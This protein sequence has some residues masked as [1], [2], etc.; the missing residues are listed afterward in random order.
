RSAG[1]TRPATSRPMIALA[2]TVRHGK[3]LSLWNTKPRSPP[4]PRTARPSSV[5][6]PELAGSRPATMR[7]NVVLPQPDGPTSAMNSP[8]STA[9]LMSCNARNSPKVLPRWETWSLRAIR[10]NPW[11]LVLGPRHEPIFQPAETRGERDP[12]DRGHDHAGKQL[13]HVE[14]VG[15]L[16]DQAPE[17]RARAEQLRHHHPDQ[18]ASDP[19]LEPGKDERH[20]GRQ[21]HLEE[22][23]PRGRAERAQHLDQP[24][25]GGAQPGLGVDGHRK[26]HQEDDHQHLRPDADPEPE[27][28]QR[29]ERD[30]RRGV[31]SRDPRL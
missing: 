25:A 23:L 6:S 2:N 28:E 12:S 27:N 19:E 9:R 17:S 15:R 16:R 7:R 11:A 18:A 14:G 8:R 29:G 5:T 22:N 24:I 4:G 31:E 26:Q 1:P 13:R 30:G 20:R 3:R 21:R 10:S